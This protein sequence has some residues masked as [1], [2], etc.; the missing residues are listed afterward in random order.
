MAGLAIRDSRIAVAR[1]RS[2]REEFSCLD[3]LFSGK[4]RVA[5]EVGANPYKAL[6][7]VQSLAPTRPRKAHRFSGEVTTADNPFAG[8]TGSRDRPQRKA[9]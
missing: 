9:V 6:R 4:L 3:G 7:D 2:V 8:R 5:P 1:T